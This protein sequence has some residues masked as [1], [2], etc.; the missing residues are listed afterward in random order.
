MLQVSKPDLTDAELRAF[1]QVLDTGYLG[2]GDE[3]QAFE[4]EIAQYLATGRSVVCTHTGTSALHTALQA[5]GIG[6]GDEVLIPT[7]GYVAAFQAIFVTGAKPVPCDICPHNGLIDLEDAKQR[8]SARTRAVV[9][10]H[11]AGGA[12]NW[13]DVYTF[14]QAHGLRVI[15]D[16][17]HAFGNQ[18]KGERIGAKGDVICFSF[19]PIKNITS[20][21]GGAVVTGDPDVANKVFS[22]RK[23]G[24]EARKNDFDVLEKGWRYHMPNMMAAIGR[25][26]LARFES[27]IKPL[28]LQQIQ[29]YRTMLAEVEEVRIVPQPTD[30]FLH[31]LPLC[32]PE[33][34]RDRIREKLLEKNFQTTLHYKPNH[35]LTAFKTDYSLPHSEHFFQQCF[36]PPLN[37]E[38]TEDHIDDIVHIIKEIII[39]H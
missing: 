3:V 11:Y 13:D 22:S 32:V 14:A 1:Q 7:I 37:C 23:L 8:V 28:R 26:Q 17:A 29:W 35:L 15:E 34:S 5:I 31:I 33:K 39:C 12:D 9:T 10:V 18:H 24:I 27:E 25:T 2:M 4:R 38:V 20:G 30:N 6:P 36:S 21:E 16:A 19:D